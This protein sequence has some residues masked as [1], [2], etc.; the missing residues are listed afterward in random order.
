MS[1]SALRG[2]EVFLAHDV[3]GGAAE[4][5]VDAPREGLVE[6]YSGNDSQQIDPRRWHAEEE[7]LVGPEPA[8]L[9]DPS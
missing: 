2:D 6:L 9:A 4:L 7:E 3:N 8:R 5:N 1:G